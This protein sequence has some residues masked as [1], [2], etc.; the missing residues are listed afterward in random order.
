MHIC[1]IVDF[2]KRKAIEIGTDISIA[3]RRV[4]KRDHP[5]ALAHWGT[6]GDHRWSILP[7][8]TIYIPYIYILLYLLLELPLGPRYGAS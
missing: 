1:L 6:W 7:V 8:W 4:L 5:S 2:Y 3:S